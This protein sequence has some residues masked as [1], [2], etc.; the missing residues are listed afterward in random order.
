M[1]DRLGVE[2]VCSDQ[3]IAALRALPPARAISLWHSLEHL[4]APDEML[5]VAADRLQPGGILALGVPNPS[6]LQFRLLGKRWAH[7]DAPRHLCLM[8]EQALVERLQALGLTRVAAMTGDPFG[9][10]C[11]IHGWTYAMRRRPALGETATPLK[12]AG[13]QLARA[14]APIEHAQRRGPALT[15]LAAKAR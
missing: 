13:R 1:R 4:H 11:S 12:H 5:A 2:T 6:S 7:L 9:V 15:L 10:I 14:L 8:P 3:P